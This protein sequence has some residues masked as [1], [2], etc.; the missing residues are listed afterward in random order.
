M[1]RIVITGGCGYIGSHIA[2]ALKKDNEKTQ[3]FVIDKQ[4][5]DNT[6]VN[7][8]GYLIDDFSSKQSLMWIESLEPHVIIH[9]A[10]SSSVGES[11]SNPSEYYDNNIAKTIK[12]LD[13]L[14]DLSTKPLVLFSSSASVY[15]N[16]DDSPIS[17]TS[18][19]NPL[20]PYGF[21]KV[22][23]EKALADYHKAYEL[24]SICFRYFNAAGAEPF[25][26]DLGET[27]GS[28]H[29][30]AK[31]LEAS[32][33]KKEFVLN[34]NDYP[35]K[36]GTCI[37]DYVHVW[38]IALAHVA[39]IKWVATIDEIPQRVMNLGSKHGVSNKE[40]LDYVSSKY[41]LK[42]IVSG[43]RRSG[44]ANILIANCELAT[45]LL[46]WNPQYSSIET[47]IDSAYQWYTN[48]YKINDV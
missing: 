5:R 33:N 48:W 11:I 16:V 38:D 44:D 2:R 47:I 8:N 4:R 29:I 28:G 14:K 27:L 12:L 34:G 24:P 26:Y 9:C 22:V 42:E 18:P 19:T 17:E 46:N 3:I 13:Y 41:Q 43:K 7:V 20:S 40:I 32:L 6:L 30:I 23:I 25:T 10:G 15:G 37:R 39:A 31:I 45:K 36:D 21:S 35:T 1:K